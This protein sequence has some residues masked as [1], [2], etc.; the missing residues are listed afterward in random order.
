MK[1]SV[2]TV[3]I[4]IGVFSS[5]LYGQLQKG[6]FG[7]Y[8]TLS[9][10]SGDFGDDQGFDAGLAKTGFGAGIEFN[11]PLGTPGLFWTSNV[12]LL[13]NGYDVDKD[14]VEDAREDEFVDYDLDIEDF[15]L[16]IGSYL[17]IPIM[18]GLKWVLTLSPTAELYGVGQAGINFA[19][20]PGF[21]EN[22]T[23][24]DEFGNEYDY[25]RQVKYS[26]TSSL[27][28]CFGIGLILNDKINIGLRYLG[29]R[30]PEAE[31]TV[32]VEFYGESGEDEF[33]QDQPISIILLT[34]GISL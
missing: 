18:S 12:W 2:L 27:G 4:V 33:D 29:M 3:V 15:D 31:G 9:I 32:E 10:P 7:V 11:Y 13:Y 16:E 5:A 34:A 30:E 6:R 1:R 14:D 25:T 22:L 8:G 23:I 26:L 21:E 24:S 17:N 20:F 19:K 28:F